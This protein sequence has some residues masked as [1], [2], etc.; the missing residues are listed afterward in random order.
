ML[1]DIVLQ[2]ANTSKCLRHVVMDIMG[3]TMRYWMIEWVEGT[4][5]VGLL[6]LSEMSESRGK[7]MIRKERLEFN[8]RL[9]GIGDVLDF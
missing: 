4:G 9:G 8:D 3:S 5:D 7:D 1:E 6:N 2:I